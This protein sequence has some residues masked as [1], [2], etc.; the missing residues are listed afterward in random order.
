MKVF[1]EFTSKIF[2]QW[3]IYLGFI[4]FIYDLLSAYLGLN[5]KFPQ[6]IILWFPIMI[7]LY[8]TYQIYRDEYFRRIKIEQKL[9]SPTDYKII[10]KLYPVDY[11]EDTKI[12][13]LE[14]IKLE[15]ENRL[16]SLPV[17]MK[18]NEVEKH[19]HSNKIMSVPTSFYN[20]SAS[21]YNDE[22]SLYKS[23]LEE[24]VSNI[25]I[26]KEK[27]NTKI[28]ELGNIFYFIEFYIENVGI[29]S[30]SEIQVDIKCLNENIVFP[31]A[32]ILSHGM[33][34]YNLMPKIPN[35]PEKPK[36]QSPYDDMNNGLMNPVP[37][38]FDI[39]NP[40]AFRK[41]VEINENNCSL[42]IRDLQVGDKVNLFKKKLI[43]M[44]NID[45]ISF[46][47]T[48]KSKESTKIL[49]PNV[50]VDISQTKKTLFDYGEN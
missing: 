15:A 45:D 16:S 12:K 41:C 7:L 34:L 6:W 26:F 32:Q 42:T 10:A 17:Y 14:D 11:E 23:N 27:I 39:P 21:T 49:K 38:N 35:L 40:N 47:V 5:Y 30:D 9:E 25:E 1:I 46:S 20:K 3:I 48:I 8:A 4:P 36:I 24:I 29:T 43:I 28:K 31:E 13:Q 2:K 22:L 50:I 37:P 44:K 19:L 18:V 33:N